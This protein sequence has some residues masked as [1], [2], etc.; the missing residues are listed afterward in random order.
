MR[1][2]VAISLLAVACG[3]EK[4]ALEVAGELRTATA[5]AMEQGSVDEAQVK[6]DALFAHLEKHQLGG[7][8]DLALRLA[9]RYA[10]AWQADKL[11]AKVSRYFESYKS[12]TTCHR[13]QADTRWHDP[14][15]L[16]PLA[17]RLARARELFRRA[18]D[19][20]RAAETS[21]YL[22]D[23]E[24]VEADLATAHQPPCKPSAP[25][26]APST[27]RAQLAIQ[28]ALGRGEPQLAKRYAQTALARA[29]DYPNAAIDACRARIYLGY[30]AEQELLFSDAREH[31]RQAGARETANH[32][33]TGPEGDDACY[34]TA[35]ARLAGLASARD[36]W[37]LSRTTLF[38]AVKAPPS[39]VV[40]VALQAF[41]AI[42]RSV[43][44]APFGTQHAQDLRHPWPA[45][46]V[47]WVDAELEGGRLIARL[48][49][50]HWL[51]QVEIEPAGRWQ[52][53]DGICLDAIEVKGTPG[54]VLP[55]LPAL[56]FVE[57]S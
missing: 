12:G 26:P 30:F 35:A 48:P 3:K 2:L 42:P 56:E 40:R 51:P 5:T 54:E 34:S 22:N 23:L 31:Y 28:L 7:S 11:P 45:R 46:T 17:D 20:W 43:A 36:Q 29:K 32:Q 24:G 39:T 53:A 55:E 27:H 47:F 21:A 15:A 9:E 1:S 33:W 13:A 49:P 18:C 8:E 38:G 4:T 52:L 37:A 57:R 44:P 41:P 6:L 50:G 14:Q 16:A 25:H 10:E 19:F